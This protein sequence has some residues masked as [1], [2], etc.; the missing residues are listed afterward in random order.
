MRKNGL[1]PYINHPI[2]VM[3]NAAKAGIIELATLQACVL[4][5]TVEDTDVEL[6]E[7]R[8]HFGEHVANIVNNV[9]D[10][11]TMAKVERKKWQIAHAGSICHEAKIVKLCDKLDNLSGQLVDPPSGWSAQ[12]IQGYF[13]W[14]YH[15]VDQM[16]GTNKWLEDELDKLF[17]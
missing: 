14:A 12:R 1:A 16:R 7:I 8:E 11:K 4:H 10:D 9:S 3:N 6:N 15:V 17:E 2:A 5:D 13:V